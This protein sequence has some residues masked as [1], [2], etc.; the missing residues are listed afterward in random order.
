MIPLLLGALALFAADRPPQLVVNPPYVTTPARV[1]E[2]MVSLAEIRRDDVVYDLGC[3]D[4]RLVIAALRHGAARG[5]GIDLFPE[6]I[7]EARARAT[8]AGVAT[9]VEFRQADLFDS[10]FREATVL[11]MYLMPEINLKLRDRLR[12]D[13][14]PGARIVSHAFDMGDWKPDRVVEAYGAKLYLWRV[15]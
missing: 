7:A 6:H 13:L 15:R 14:R 8:E 9:R 2:A 11:L 3:G 4:G 1:V 5:V 12:R 10:N